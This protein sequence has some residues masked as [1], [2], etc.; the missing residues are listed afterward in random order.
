M[1][2]VLQSFEDVN[3]NALLKGRRGRE[4][5]SV[6]LAGSTASFLHVDFVGCY[7]RGHSTHHCR[8]LLRLSFPATVILPHFPRGSASCL[9]R[10]RAFELPPG[11]SP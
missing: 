3:Y 1:E 10:A 5:A 6:S 7:R 9:W 11:S 2:Q 4:E 8:G